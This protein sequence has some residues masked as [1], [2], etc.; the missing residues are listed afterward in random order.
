MLLEL[1]QTWNSGETNHSLSE[2]S[3]PNTQPGC[4]LIQFHAIPMVPVSVPRE[5]RSTPAFP[6][7]L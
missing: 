2:E 4:P 7:P 5:K 3:F 6:L 1:Y